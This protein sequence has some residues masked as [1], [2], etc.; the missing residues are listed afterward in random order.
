MKNALLEIRTIS[1]DYK[2]AY[3]AAQIKAGE[4]LFQFEPE[5][6]LDH[7]T[8]YTVQ[9]SKT[10][11]IVLKPQFLQYVNHSCAPNVFFD[12]TKMELV[13]LQDIEMGEELA[14]F[15]PSTEW[16]MTEPFDCKCRSE[17]CLK[18]ISGAAALDKATLQKYRLSAYIMDGLPNS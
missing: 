11:H 16:E 2:A 18:K 7:A 6:V 13:A 15:Y 17:Q 4:V 9:I 3:A 8:R 14:F 10:E 12:T 5:E 1:D